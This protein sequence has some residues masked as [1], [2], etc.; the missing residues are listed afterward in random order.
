MSGLQLSLWNANGLRTS[1]VQDVLSHCLAKYTFSSTVLTP[2]ILFITETWLLAPTLLPTDWTQYHTYGDP[3]ANSTRGSMGLCALVSPSCPYLV[4][5]IPSPNK[6]TLALKIGS[7]RVYCLYLP[8]SIADASLIADILLSI[9]VRANTIVCGDFNARLGRFTGDRLLNARGRALKKWA[10]DYELAILNSSL[11]FRKPTWVGMSEDGHEISSIIDLFLTNASLSNASMTVETNLSLNSDHR[12]LHLYFQSPGLITS[13]RDSTSSVPRLHPRRL[14]N[15]SRLSE[16]GCIHLYS[17]TFAETSSSLLSQVSE[18]EVH[19]PST[20]PDIEGLNTALLDSLYQSLDKAVG[21]RSPRPAHWKK[22]WTASLESAARYRDNTY[23]AW[24]RARPGIDKVLCHQQLE[25]AKQNFRKEVI[26]AKRQSWR[27]FCASLEL[28]PSKAVSKMKHLKRR[29]EQAGN[30]STYSHPDGPLAAVDSMANHL[31]SVYNGQLLPVSRPVVSPC[32]LDRSM[33]PLPFGAPSSGRLC[34][35]S[36]PDDT[37]FT[38]D[39]SP[40]VAFGSPSNPG[41]GNIGP[42]APGDGPVTSVPALSA[43]STAILRNLFAPTVIEFLIQQLPSRKAP[44]SDHIKAEM[45]KPIRTLLA[46]ILSHLFT[47]CWQWSFVPSSWRHAQVFPIFKKGDPTSPSNYRPISLT[48]VFRKLLECALQPALQRFSPRLDLAQG[49]F[50]PRRSAL[51]QALCLHE[52]MLSYFR[53]HHHYPV[54]AFLDIK[55]AYDTVD[56]RVIWNSL[57]SQG[58]PLD[59]LALLSHLFD[60]VS[61]SVLISG[62]CSSPFSPS[63]G[64]LQGSVLSPHLYSLY[65]NSLPRLLRQVTTSTTHCVNADD[66]GFITR[67]AVSSSVLSIPSGVSGVSGVSV[68][69]GVSGVPGVSVSSG[70]S[71]VPVPFG[72]SGISVD[73]SSLAGSLVSLSRGTTAINSLLFADDVAIFGSKDSVL[74]MLQLAEQHSYELGYRWNPLKCAVLNH[75]STT[76]STS[77]SFSLSLY[78]TPLPRVDEFVYLGV[79]FVKNGLSTPAL[80]SHR[81]PGALKAMGILNRIG[82]NRQGFS[83][84]LCARLY[85]TFVRPKFEYG[86]AISNFRGP[87]Y[88]RLEKLQDRCLRILFGGRHNASTAVFKHLTTLPDMR[89]RCDVL[90]TRYVLR[91]ESLPR[92]CLLK[93]LESTLHGS[94]IQHCLSQNLLYLAVPHPR[95]AT[96]VLLKAFFHDQRVLALAGTLRRSPLVLLGACRPALEV[97]PIL[98][99]PATRAERSRLVRWRLGWLPSGSG[100]EDCLCTHDRRSRRHVLDC[101]CVPGYLWDDLPPRPHP[102]SHPIDAALNRLPLHPLK[103]P[104]PPWW[105]TLLTILWYVDCSCHPG[106]L[107]PADPS[108]GSRWI[109]YSSTSD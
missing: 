37:G 60:D 94:R 4:S 84:S 17:N 28:E 13:P 56:R 108:P 24:R 9:P 100:Y 11:A 107:I 47:I 72:V 20:R 36:R 44:G 109:N 63:T 46:P 10:D 55:A 48:S 77:S 6:Y 80:L 5:Q 50:R 83:L 59:F 8:P 51:D 27:D 54:V 2:S 53:H 32:L 62:H 97:D 33:L 40:G 3:V 64:V 96:E 58:T 70:V 61:V 34:S 15:L 75:P 103:T 45:L 76:S 42:G 102:D 52:L 69:S 19:P 66:N 43:G 67:S 91:S 7:L 87:D 81:S 86:L 18:L 31:A 78:G 26:L 79:P 106:I 101:P 30:P 92:S 41:H 105:S 74:S 25:K 71:G 88:D 95:P 1:V 14:W 90:V 23:C 65:I 57:E 99:L 68:S 73:E 93:L 89:S 82:V 35:S 38:G 98:Y 104:A 29:H 85:S 22:Y 39:G 49:G 21:H 12:L 16:D